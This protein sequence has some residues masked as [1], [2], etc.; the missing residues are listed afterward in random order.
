MEPLYFEN[1]AVSVQP[2]SP[3]LSIL[4]SLHKKI[5][6]LEGTLETIH[7]SPILIL[8]LRNCV[9]QTL[10][11]LLRITQTASQLDMTLRVLIPTYPMFFVVYSDGYPP[12]YV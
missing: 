1:G 7:S 8:Y 10:S 3:L 9:P 5:L 12:V 11:D 6:E 2:L 4:L